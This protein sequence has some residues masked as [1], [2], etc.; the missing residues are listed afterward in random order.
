AALQAMRAHS[1]CIQCEV[2]TS[3]E[4][5][6]SYNYSALMTKRTVVRANVLVF[7]AL[8]AILLLLGGLTWDRFEAAAV[9]RQWSEHSHQ[10]IEAIKD[11][12]LAIRD[13]ET[14]QRGYILT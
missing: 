7:V 3:V 11:L 8:I 2:A 12:N 4:C 6:T 13:A 1:S 10:V 14:G 9:A 5:A